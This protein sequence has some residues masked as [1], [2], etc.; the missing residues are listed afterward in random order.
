MAK[1]MQDLSLDS[2][3][4]TALA[5][6]A[7]LVLM[8]LILV[9]ITR[10]RQ[11]SQAELVIILVASLSVA[12]AGALTA[13]VSLIVFA[14]GELDWLGWAL[15]IL[16]GIATALYLGVLLSRLGWELPILRRFL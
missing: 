13:T 3:L 15:V 4:Y 16:R 6:S 10:N 1:P 9:S 7:V 14:P 12:A 2:A 5:W 8:V 11:V